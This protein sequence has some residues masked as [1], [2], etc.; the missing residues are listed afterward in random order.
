MAGDIFLLI[1]GDKGES[2][3]SKHKDEIDI[4]SFSWGVSNSGSH[5][6]GGGGGAGKASFSDFN[7]SISACKASPN[8]M[9]KCAT[10]EHIKKAVL[11]VRKQ[12]GEQQEYYMV[13]MSDLLISSY[14]S[15]AAGETPMD[16]F[17]INYS[18][19][20]FEYKPQKADGTLDAGVKGGY[21]LKL[22][23]KV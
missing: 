8:L 12:G 5:A 2:T 21:D 23:K 11:T 10:G 22:N 1:D 7:F 14:Q 3:D 16:S 15:S 6:T 13:T 18:K 9:M 19:V 4:Q 17:S 20:E